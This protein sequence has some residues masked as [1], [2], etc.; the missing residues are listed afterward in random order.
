MLDAIAEGEAVDLLRSVL[1]RARRG[2]QAAAALVMARIWPVR[3]GRPVTLTLPLLS[4]PADLVAALG[5]IAAAI[6]RGEL[7]PDEGQAI[8]AV[9][10]QQRRAIETVQLE[11]RIATLE[12]RQHDR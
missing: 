4:T 12:A 7:T 9:L 3:K 2:D 8:A 5:N 11:Q 1:R 6:V 10:E